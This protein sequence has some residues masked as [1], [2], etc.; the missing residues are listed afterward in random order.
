[1]RTNVSRTSNDD[2]PEVAGFL[3]M[4]ERLPHFVKSK[5]AIDH[6]L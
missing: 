5:D 6:G 2:F 3:H 4:V 1:M